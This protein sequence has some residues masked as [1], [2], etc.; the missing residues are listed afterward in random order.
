MV[1]LAATALKRKLPLNDGSSMS[2]RVL[3]AQTDVH[4]RPAVGATT[5]VGE[6][7]PSAICRLRHSGSERTA[8]V[9]NVG[10]LGRK[11]CL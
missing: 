9:D 2:S 1:W 11:C 5:P 6:E 4:P 7:L 10:Q 3:E 8:I